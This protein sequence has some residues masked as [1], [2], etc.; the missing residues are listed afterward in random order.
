MLKIQT[1][2][3]KVS[4]ARS[5]NLR[6]EIISALKQGQESLKIETL[7]FPLSESIKINKLRKTLRFGSV[8]LSKTSQH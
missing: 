5:K 8:E 3:A 2:Q 6:D 1:K 7:P 4:E